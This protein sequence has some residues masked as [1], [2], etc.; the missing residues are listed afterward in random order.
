M[1]AFAVYAMTLSSDRSDIPCEFSG[2]I[3]VNYGY[4][5]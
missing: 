4:E 5:L 3:E 1:K 2:P